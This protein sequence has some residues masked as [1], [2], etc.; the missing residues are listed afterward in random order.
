MNAASNTARED[1]RVTQELCCQK[2]ELVQAGHLSRLVAGVPLFVVWRNGNPR[3]FYD[4]CSHQAVTLSDFG[5]VQDDTILCN[6]HGAIF[7]LED[8]APLKE[9]ACQSLRS[10]TA[11]VIGEQVFVELPDDR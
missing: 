7:S 2:D 3:A 5:E 11:T 6:A 4:Q 8:G 10:Y 9:P 1:L